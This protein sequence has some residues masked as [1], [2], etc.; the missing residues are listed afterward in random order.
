MKIHIAI[1]YLE[2]IKYFVS[3]VSEIIF[4]EELLSD[5]VENIQDYI[6]PTSD[7]YN[8]YK[9]SILLSKKSSQYQANP[10]DN[11]GDFGIDIYLNEKYKHVLVHMFF[12]T[13]LTL[14]INT[15]DDDGVVTTHNLETTE[16]DNLYNSDSIYNETSDPAIWEYGKIKLNNTVQVS[17][18]RVRDLRLYSFLMVIKD[19]NYQPQPSDG[20]KR[21]KF[22]RISEDGSYKHYEFN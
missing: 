17:D 6:K 3:D 20:R 15:A 10:G 5:G 7:K 14:T 18:L 12:E 13:D 9:F 16:I 21:T 4:D 22:I 8:G 2:G 19:Q 11:S 1:L